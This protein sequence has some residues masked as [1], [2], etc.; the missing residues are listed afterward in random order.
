MSRLNKYHW[1]AIVGII[2]FAILSIRSC[3]TKNKQSISQANYPIQVIDNELRVGDVVLYRFIPIDGGYMDFAYK[4]SVKVSDSDNGVEGVNENMN[5]TRKEIPSFLIGET[6]VPVNLLYF[7]MKNELIPKKSIESFEMFYA[8]N[9]KAEEWDDVIKKLEQYT[10]HRFRLPTSEEWEYAARGGQKSK[11]Y[12]YAGSDN[13][14]E[15]AHYK[16]NT[17][18][19]KFMR[20]K[21]K[22][23]NELGLYD[24]SGGVLELTSSKLSDVDSFFLLLEDE[25]KKE[26]D[27]FYLI[28]E[29]IS[30]GGCWSDGPQKCEVRYIEHGVTVRTG[31]RLIMEY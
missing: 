17:P 9:L 1:L 18:S 30:R 14:D 3:K 12:K 4:S 24:M 10:G 15:V 6:P 20:G 5:A 8:G 16:G 25:L 22:K 7:M 19:E 27:N 23:P 26:G 28:G 11:G 31:A 2:V 13:I 21:E 29:R